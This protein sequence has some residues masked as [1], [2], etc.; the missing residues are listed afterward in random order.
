MHTRTTC[1]VS[2]SYHHT[3]FIFFR[4]LSELLAIIPQ[5]KV[6]GSGRN[7]DG[8]A[9]GAAEPTGE[10][11]HVKRHTH[12]GAYVSNL[13]L[14]QAA[15]ACPLY[16]PALLS[17]RS[18][19]DRLEVCS[20]PKHL[21]RCVVQSYYAELILT[22][23]SLQVMRMI[24]S[25][26]NHHIPGRTEDQV[27]QNTTG[28]HRRKRDREFGDQ[29]EGGL[30]LKGQA[31]S[32]VT[33]QVRIRTDRDGTNVRTPSIAWY[34]RLGI[35]HG[36]EEE[37][38][39]EGSLRE[40][41]ME[42][43]VPGPEKRKREW[44]CSTW[45]G[46]IL[47]S[48]VYTQCFTA[49]APLLCGP[50][51][52][53]RTNLFSR[54]KG[55]IAARANP[56]RLV[57]TSD[58]GWYWRR[59]S[60]WRDSAWDQISGTVLWD[61]SL[62]WVESVPPTADFWS[63]GG[64]FCSQAMTE[65]WV[66]PPRQIHTV[67]VSSLSS[68]RQL[69]I[70]E[71]LC[72]WETYLQRIIGGHFDRASSNE[73]I[74]VETC[75]NDMEMVCSHLLRGAN[76]RL[77]PDEH[78]ANRGGHF[79]N[80]CFGGMHADVEGR[81]GGVDGGASVRSDVGELEVAIVQRFVRLLSLAKQALHVIPS[82]AEGNS[83]SARGNVL[84]WGNSSLSCQEQAFVAA[85]ERERQRER[86]LAKERCAAVRR[87]RVEQGWL[88]WKVL[89][90]FV[91]SADNNVD[92]DDVVRTVMP[93]H[94][95]S[96]REMSVVWL[97]LL[98]ALATP[99]QVDRALSLLLTMVEEMLG[100]RRGAE[101]RL[102]ANEGDR[103]RS[104]P[105]RRRTGRDGGSPGT[106]SN[107]EASSC[108]E[109]LN[110]LRISLLVARGT[111][112][113]TPI[114]TVIT[115]L[116]TTVTSFAKSPTAIA[117]ER[118]GTSGVVMDARVGEENARGNVFEY[119]SPRVLAQWLLTFPF[120]A[121]T[122]KWTDLAL[123]GD[124]G[125]LSQILL[126]IPDGEGRGGESGLEQCSR[127]F[128]WV[129]GDSPELEQGIGA[130]GP[131]ARQWQG[132]KE[133]KD[134]LIEVLTRSSGRVCFEAS[135]VEAL[136]LCSFPGDIVSGG[137]GVGVEALLQDGVVG[138]ALLSQVV[139][140]R[141]ARAGEMT[142]DSESLDFEIET[143]GQLLSAVAS[144][145]WVAALA[146]P[147]CGQGP[148]SWP[149]FVQQLR[150]AS[151][152]PE[153]FGQLLRHERPEVRRRALDAAFEMRVNMKLFVPLARQLLLRLESLT[154]EEECQVVL[155]IIR[156]A[157]SS[158]RFYPNIASSFWYEW[159]RTAFAKVA[160]ELVRRVC[161]LG[162]HRSSER[163]RVDDSQG[164]WGGVTKGRRGA[165][166]GPGGREEVKHICMLLSLL[167]NLPI[168]D[169]EEVLGREGERMSAR[170]HLV[171]GQTG[172]ES[173]M[174]PAGGVDVDR[175][176]RDMG[177]GGGEEGS[178]EQSSAAGKGG[179]GLRWRHNGTLVQVCLCVRARA[180]AHICA[181][182]HKW[183]SL[184]VP[185]L[186]HKFTRRALAHTH[187]HAHAHTGIIAYHRRSGCWAR[188]RVDRE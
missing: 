104:I 186:G 110:S 66:H 41:G 111:E 130:A 122:G 4:K 152:Y 91:L 120:D 115:T 16:T 140:R 69:W 36:I 167:E 106:E 141:W 107:A 46:S 142:G 129:V 101:P 184:G 126:N 12:G 171:E 133:L 25:L 24:L 19:V 132:N 156:H 30:G 188:G 70:A 57:C 125:V 86:E 123:R 18:A 28:N 150:F 158:A 34:G 183:S 100:G 74:S 143:L 147:T 76:T 77:I 35:L 83:Q 149:A 157:S 175:E 84:S 55:N 151:A 124:G 119:V 181:H 139:L 176:M 8:P 172:D 99:P 67:S 169:V 47:D 168:S 42:V 31:D 146:G 22:F 10:W 51:P 38:E 131:G 88:H 54:E 73:L 97:R 94:V 102:S 81:E 75:V 6:E 128:R 7:R 96:P 80:G 48:V 60:D 162:P 113:V 71:S 11:L 136:C 37:G 49:S 178:R 137:G 103:C 26:S 179:L 145:A 39:G 85:N 9:I 170:D 117:Y 148:G 98:F 33:R 21:G 182:V 177:G 144:R 92:C 14:A 180:R 64:G 134:A 44:S 72:V 95:E 121:V 65:G 173:L 52:L 187:T 2:G 116:V 53:S 1:Q 160:E 13:L 59:G 45:L 166:G 32:D 56:P 154:T 159:M 185:A 62:A 58:H 27:F 15:V 43:E 3:L 174:A 89:T 155:E 29:G 165:W 93:A 153:S 79:G 20:L 163:Q 114:Q 161:A 127:L 108:V 68:D 109:W 112:K 50:P 82:R 138:D 87:V 105:F 23:L 5:R 17:A 135:N 164:K 78:N 61:R 63:V 40:R 90:Q 118:L